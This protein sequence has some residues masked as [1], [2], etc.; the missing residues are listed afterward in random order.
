MRVAAIIL[1]AG[2]STRMGC[3]KLLEEF[4]GQLML[5]RVAE[6]V[7]SSRARPVIVVVGNE[8]DAVRSALAKLDVHMVSNREFRDGV[9][10][11][12]RAGVA[13]LPASID[14]VLIFM[15]DMPQMSAKLIDAVIGN[16][17]PENGRDICV[18]AYRGRRGHPVLFG[19]RFFPELLLLTGDVGARSIIES[20]STF[21]G[22]VEAGDDAPLADIDTPQALAK[23]R[24]SL[25]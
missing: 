4:G 17:A 7:L 1:A 10:T 3:N 13:A 25:G 22:E 12:I 14:G 6:A 11:S 20:N 2:L 15:G 16:F 21:V 23:F 24:G 5:H 9:S 8:A 18:A 19:R